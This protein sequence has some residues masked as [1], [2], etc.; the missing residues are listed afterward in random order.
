[1]FEDFQR[2]FIGRGWHV[3]QSRKKVGRDW[4]LGRF[5]FRQTWS[6]CPHDRVSVRM[7]TWLLQQKL[8]LFPQLMMHSLP[9]EFLTEAYLRTSWYATSFDELK[10]PIKNLRLDYSDI[11]ARFRTC[12]FDVK[13]LLTLRWYTTVHLTLSIV[14]TNLDVTS[15]NPNRYFTGQL[16]Q[17]ELFQSRIP[18]FLTHSWHHT[19]AL[20]GDLSPFKTVWAHFTFQFPHG[21][22]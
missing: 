19:T 15:Q 12:G 7:V 9:S 18:E 8:G 5:Q 1:M 6:K 2:E 14:I 3:N 4:K 17:T 21:T 10:R 13:E 22:F 11:E 16:D 20:I